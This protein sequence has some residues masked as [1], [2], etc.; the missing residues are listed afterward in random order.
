MNTI[1]TFC[2]ASLLASIWALTSCDTKQEEALSPGKEM[3]ME[4]IA[5]HGGIEKWRSNGLLQFRWKYHM[6]DRGAIADSIQ[7]VDPISLAAVH[8]VPGT[9]T[10]FGRTEDGRYW[11]HPAD[12]KFV[13]PVQFWTLTPFYFLGIPFVFDDEQ[14]TYQL[15][16]ETKNFNGKEYPQVKLTYASSAGESPDDHYVLLIDPETKLVRGTY[17]TVTNPLVYKGGPVIEKFLTLDNLQDVNGLQI[18]GAHKTFAMPEGEIAAEKMRYT[19]VSQ[20]SFV[21]RSTVDF[22]PPEG[23][24]FLE[25]SPTK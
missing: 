7:T 19:D 21:D 3:V 25:V 24:R 12:A 4:S 14:I 1:A 8:T 11:V 17:Y 2:K 23:A 22:T 10:T 5:A 6:T 20:V 9:D 13:P 16:D 18:A 15:L